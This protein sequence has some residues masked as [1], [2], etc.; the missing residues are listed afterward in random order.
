M[1][2]I[3][4]IA[5]AAFKKVKGSDEVLSDAELAAFTTIVDIQFEEYIAK[6]LTP[7]PAVPAAPESG[8]ATASGSTEDTVSGPTA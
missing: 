3:T 4:D 5:V 6:R 2:L 7:A 1:G 8:T